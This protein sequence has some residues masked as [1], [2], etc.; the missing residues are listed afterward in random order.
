MAAN[1]ICKREGFKQKLQQLYITLQ[2]VNHGVAKEPRFSQI[3]KASTEE[4][5]QIIIGQST[6]FDEP[7]LTKQPIRPKLEI[8]VDLKQK[9]RSRTQSRANKDETMLGPQR[10]HQ[11][12]TFI[13]LPK[14]E[15]DEWITKETRSIKFTVAS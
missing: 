5:F 4:E 1:R 15:E 2:Q 9:T 11:D 13:T 3:F 7:N 14:Q 8:H 6:A 10:T 12:Q